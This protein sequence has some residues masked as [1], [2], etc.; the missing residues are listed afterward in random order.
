MWCITGKECLNALL[1]VYVFDYCILSLYNSA[2]ILLRDY[3]NTFDTKAWKI[4]TFLKECI[5]NTFEYLNI[6]MQASLKALSFSTYIQIKAL[7]AYVGHYKN[8][9]LIC[10]TYNHCTVGFSRKTITVTTLY[11]VKHNVESNKLFTCILSLL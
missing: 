4:F 1:S 6:V 9:S 8:T 3:H 10:C 7:S 11:F 5:N 2:C